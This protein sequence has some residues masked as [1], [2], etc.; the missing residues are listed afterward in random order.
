MRTTSYV[1]S[2]H[3][4]QRVFGLWWYFKDKSHL[5]DLILDMEPRADRMPLFRE[6]ALCPSLLPALYLEPALLAR[7]FEDDLAHPECMGII[8]PFLGST[9]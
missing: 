3:L 4:H 8:S 6:N 2:S 1:L 9:Q 7:R 5:Q